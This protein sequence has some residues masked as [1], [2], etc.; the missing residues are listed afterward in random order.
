MIRN[1][2][3]ALVWGMLNQ[4]YLFKS[5]ETEILELLGTCSSWTVSLH[6]RCS[7]V[8]CLHS[9]LWPRWCSWAKP[10]DYESVCSSPATQHISICVMHR[11]DAQPWCKL[12]R[13][14]WE[15]TA[16]ANP[17]SLI[18]LRFCCSVSWRC[19]SALL[20]SLAVRQQLHRNFHWNRRGLWVI[21]QD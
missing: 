10:S 4:E 13:L 1:N 11:C 2:L 21:R 8:L 16:W 17:F 6:W 7:P 15:F 3:L 14:W 18:A 19:L 20:C 9:P 5:R 12:R